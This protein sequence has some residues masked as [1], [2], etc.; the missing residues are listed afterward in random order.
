M[1]T[2]EKSVG[3]LFELEQEIILLQ[4]MCDKEK[5]EMNNLNEQQLQQHHQQQE[6]QYESSWD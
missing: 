6:D 4:R 5:T 3:R 2:T 1:Q